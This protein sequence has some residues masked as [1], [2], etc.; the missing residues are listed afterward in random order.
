MG[1]V[2]YDVHY[3]VTQGA[4]RNCKARMKYFVRAINERDDIY[5]L[6]KHR[7]ERQIFQLAACDVWECEI[8]RGK[9]IISTFD[10]VVLDMFKVTNLGTNACNDRTNGGSYFGE[11]MQNILEFHP[12]V[13]FAVE[14]AG[15]QTRF[16]CTASKASRR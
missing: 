5:I 7:I 2:H 11:A 3:D 12:Q 6:S 1:D 13:V 14:L 10:I 16:W 9:G 8:G 15:T 4:V